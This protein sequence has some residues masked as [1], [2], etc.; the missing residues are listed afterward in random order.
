M[1]AI[2]QRNLP[3]F[4]IAAIF[5]LAA[6]QGQVSGQQPTPTS[7]HPSASPLPFQP[8]TSAATSESVPTSSPSPTTPIEPL[9][10]PP[11]KS[12]SSALR[13]VFPTP[14][15][16][17][18]SAWRPPL[19]DV[20]WALTPYDHFY[21]ARPIAAD[22]VNWPLANYRYGAAWL[23]LENVIHTGVDI[24]APEGTPVLAAAAGKVVW[25]GY[26]LS[27]EKTDLNDP[28]GLAIMIKHD[29]GYQGERLESVYAHLSEADVVYGQEVAAGEKI[30]LVGNT[31]RTTGPHLHFEI[32]VEYSN[33][34]YTTRNPELWLVPPQG[35][36]LLVGHIMKNDWTWLFQQDVNVKSL[37]NG[38]TWLVRTYADSPAL[39]PDDYYDEN[40][41]LSDLPAGDYEV[42][43]TYEGT[44]FS[45]VVT[46]HPG[47]VSYLSFSVADKF[48]TAL[49]ST[50]VVDFLATATPTKQP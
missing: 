34:Y 42:E 10:A 32:R 38:D 24:D 35:W 47:M 41:V 37:A 28:Y 46:I 14:G 45:Q 48:S 31:G 18:I 43:M 21:F 3:I 36:G 8:S 27:S 33:Y 5:G 22:E 7:F 23:G 19:Y 16:A 39:H 2:L 1:K 12:G 13:F 11:A 17:P 20:P 15:P 6:C 40:L 44:T 4:L 29:F 9:Q 49:P 50:Q 26:G 30:G 25:V